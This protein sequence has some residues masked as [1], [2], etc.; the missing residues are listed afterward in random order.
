MP[1]SVELCQLVSRAI[2]HITWNIPRIRD[3]SHWRNIHNPHLVEN[4]T[5]INGHDRFEEA[6]FRAREI[7]EERGWKAEITDTKEQCHEHL[8]YQHYRLKCWK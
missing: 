5:R 4:P 2:N 8:Y 1:K 7:M 6:I 3:G